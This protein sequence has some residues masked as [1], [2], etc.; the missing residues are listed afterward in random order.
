MSTATSAA[1]NAPSASSTSVTTGLKAAETGCNA[2]ISA[3][4][5]APVTRLF[6]SS[7]SPTSAGDNR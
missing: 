2:K 1:R 6:S 7:C 4:N 3:T 5:A